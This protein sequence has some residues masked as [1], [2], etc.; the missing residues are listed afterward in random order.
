MQQRFIEL[1]N[2]YTDLFEFIELAKA[3]RHRFQRML[4]LHTSIDGKAVTSPVLI[5]KPTDPGEFQ[6]LYI[7]LEGI[8]NPHVQPNKR[9]TLFANTARDL[10]TDIIELEVKPSVDFPDKHLYYQYLIGILRM[11][12]YIAPLL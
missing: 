1:G 12:K 7:C 9:Y 5:L 8:P 10:K 2:G 3:N 6:A 11:N 4:T